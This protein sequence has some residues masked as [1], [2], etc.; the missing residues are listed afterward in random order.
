VLIT[1]KQSNILEDLDTLRL[2]S[3]LVPEFCGQSMEEDAVCEHAFD[4]IFAF[5]EAGAAEC[6]SM[7][8][9]S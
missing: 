5:D 7:D 1:N 9:Q 4:L 8:S 6:M 2:L 3:K